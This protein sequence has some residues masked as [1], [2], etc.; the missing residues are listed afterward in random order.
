MVSEISDF[1]KLRFTWSPKFRIWHNGDLRGLRNFGSG[2]IVM[3]MVSKISD[4]EHMRFTW[5]HKF[6]IWPNPDL[7]G[8]RNF[9]FRQGCFCSFGFGALVHSESGNDTTRASASPYLL[10]LIGRA[11]VPRVS[12]LCHSSPSTNREIPIIIN[13]AQSIIR[14]IQSIIK[15]IAIQT[16]LWF[17]MNG[18]SQIDGCR[19]ADQPHVAKVGAHPLSGSGP[20]RP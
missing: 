2:Q 16:K 8:L 14:K 17:R 19:P 1:A 5:S 9:G 15:D 10:D 6:R 7:H 12:P 13:A 11:T 3:C 4:A 20:G 18:G